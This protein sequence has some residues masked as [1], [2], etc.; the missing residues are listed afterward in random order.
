MVWTEEEITM[1]RPLPD[2]ELV[3]LYNKAGIPRENPEART[4][5]LEERYLNLT[6]GDKSRVATMRN[7]KGKAAALNLLE[8]FAASTSYS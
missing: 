2:L 7:E 6:M 3:S 5:F 1:Y 8:R 4:K